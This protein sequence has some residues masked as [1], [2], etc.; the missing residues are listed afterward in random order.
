MASKEHIQR[1]EQ[2][3]DF[4]VTHEL[5]FVQ[6]KQARNI[7]YWGQDGRITHVENVWKPD[8]I[9]TVARTMPRR[10]FV[11]PCRPLCGLDLKRVHAT[12]LTCN[13]RRSYYG[14]IPDRRPVFE[15]RLLARNGDGSARDR[16]RLT[17]LKKIVTIA[18]FF[19]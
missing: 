6:N 19:C 10:L 12:C 4:E 3:L 5:V 16:I 7:L 15:I 2:E 8:G 17:V 9:R 14:M 18:E 13:I 1:R 11:M